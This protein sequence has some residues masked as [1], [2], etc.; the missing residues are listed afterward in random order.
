MDSTGL[1]IGIELEVLLTPISQLEG[2]FKDLEHFCLLVARKWNAEK[3]PGDANMHVDIDGEYNGG[4]E[5]LEWSITDDETLRG[6]E[7]ARA[8]RCE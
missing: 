4:N 7:D 8:G 5:N 3:A 1:Q 2:G 6:L